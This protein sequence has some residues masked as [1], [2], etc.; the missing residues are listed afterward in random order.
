MKK[1]VILFIIFLMILG[2]GIAEHFFVHKTF[3]DFNERIGKIEAALQNNDVENALAYAE[4]LQNFWARKRK[5]VEAISYCQDARQVNVILG[6]LTGSLRCEDTD[7]AFSKIESLYQLIQNIRDM[8]DFNA[9]DI[10]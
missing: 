4:D 3:D 5:L 8:L 6:E 2:A 9:I 7:N 1:A 10:I